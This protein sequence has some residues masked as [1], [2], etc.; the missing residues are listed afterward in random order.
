MDQGLA[1]VM[2]ALMGALASGGGSYISGIYADKSQKKQARR[3]VYLVFLSELVA[4][5]AQIAK[6]REVMFYGSRG[7][8]DADAIEPGLENLGVAVSRLR[9]LEIG[10]RLEGPDSVSSLA[11]NATRHISWLEPRMRFVYSSRLQEG[12][13]FEM[14]KTI[15]RD[16]S[17][18]EELVEEIRQEA[19]RHL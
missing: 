12:D 16:C 11:N 8:T 14:R 7:E 15:E 10:V 2:G 1:A 4:V 17:R 9:S 5:E 19:P 6:L 3:E 13:L 18:L